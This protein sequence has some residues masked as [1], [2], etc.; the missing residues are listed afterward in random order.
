[1][2][3]DIYHLWELPGIIKFAEVRYFMRRFERSSDILKQV[4]DTRHIAIWLSFYKYL[5]R[6]KHVRNITQNLV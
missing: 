1:M 6:A 4:W 3:S 5:A 2:V